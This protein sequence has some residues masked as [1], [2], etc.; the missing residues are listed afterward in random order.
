MIQYKLKL[1]VK[2]IIVIVS[3]D[4]QP[5]KQIIHHI[6]LLNLIFPLKIMPI[7]F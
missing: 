2:Y 7:S 1:K 4:Q 3:N 5:F 6:F